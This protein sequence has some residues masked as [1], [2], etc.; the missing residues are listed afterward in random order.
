MPFAP[1]GAKRLLAEKGEITSAEAA[2][3][4]GFDQGTA[5]VWLGRLVELSLA[6]RH[7]IG[8]KGQRGGRK[9][10]YRA[11]EAARFADTQNGNPKK[12]KKR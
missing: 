3:A 1:K 7:S 10:V 12:P 5:R 4:L 9:V 6:T 11:Q 8:I 2:K